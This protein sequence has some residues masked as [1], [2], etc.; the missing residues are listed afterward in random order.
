MCRNVL[1]LFSILVATP[2][3]AA[4][5]YQTVDAPDGV[6]LNVVTIGNPDNP[7]ILFI[8]GFAQS[9]YSFVR[10]FESDLAEDF[11]LVSFD[12]RGHGSSGKP[13]AESAYGSSAVWAQDVDTVI[14]AT[15]ARRPVVVAWSY[16]TLVVMDYVRESG[17]DGIAGILL[18]GGLGQLRPFRAPESDDPD[19]EPDPDAEAFARARE[20]QVSPSIADNVRASGLMMEWLTAEPLPTAERELLRTITLMLPTYARKAMI[21]RSTK[22]A[23]PLDNGDLLDVLRLPVL[24]SIGS[25]D[26]AIVFGDAAELAEQ[27]DNFR[28]SEYTGAGHSIFLEQPDRFNAEL[29][30]F[31]SDAHAIA[32]EDR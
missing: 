16:G 17:V 23:A 10:Q 3:F 18:T 1:I 12:L 20:L 27:R 13:W 31:A 8:H 21:A 4:W 32:G 14:A 2:C 15:N 28:F 25:E 11:F 22:L 19:A 24:L 26:N 6:P 29:R 30:R 5:D 7:A 9:H